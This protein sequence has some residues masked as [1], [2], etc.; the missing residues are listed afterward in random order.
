MIL[1]SE[2]HQRSNQIFHDNI[3][4][5]LY[6]DIR[7]KDGQDKGALFGW[8]NLN[9]KSFPFIYSE[10]TGYAVTS[11]SWIYASL[12]NYLALQAARESAKWIQKNIQSNLLFARP[13]ALGSVPNDL[14]ELFYSFDNGMIVIGLVNLYK[15]TKDL[16][17][18]LLAEKITQTLI[19]RFFDGE[20]LIARLDNSC[21]PM[22]E[23]D[24]KGIVKWSTI[25]GAYHAKLSLALLE[26][27]RLTNNPKYSEVSNSI[28]DYAIKTQCSDGHFMTNPGSDIVFLHP[29]LYACE[30]LIYSGIAQSNEEHH[31][32][33]LNGILWAIEQAE[34]SKV[35]GLYSNT[36]TYAVE[37]SD[38][39]AQLVRLL[40]LCRS[41]LG[42]F[43]NSS[44]LDNV[45]Q[46][47]H[48]R[49]LDFY[50]ANGNDR[51]GMRYQLNLDSACSWCTMFSMQALHLWKMKNASRLSWLDY[52]V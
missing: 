52:F 6:S 44:K 14:S 24:T 9:S 17:N 4:W 39:T 2:I 8:K 37:Q 18:L 38:C 23:E 27:S 40:I 50:I 10:I 46:S 7:I 31:R 11:F 36:G 28:C 16:G 22:I 3:N 13:A 25:S 26:L 1:M 34:S 5:L 48:S 21:N 35:G 47:L 49:L 29:H 30:G 51:G 41:Q 19:D 45:I 12:G 32:V 33:G 42:K 15:I 43:I 20:K